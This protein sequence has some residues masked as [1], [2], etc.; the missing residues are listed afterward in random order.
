MRTIAGILIIAGL[1]MIPSSF[2]LK[3]IDYRESRNK[4][5]CKVLKGDVLLYFVFVDNKETAPWTEFDIR[6]TLDSIAT[7]VK[8]LH[9]QAAA[10]GVPLRIKTDYY[11]GKEYSTVS[12]NLTYGT[13]SKTI[14]KLGLRK[15]LEELNTWGDNVAKR[16]GSA[17]VMPEKDGIPEIKNP[18]NK[19]RLVA[20]LR[21]DH[22]V[23]SVALL[24]FLNNY[25]RVDISLQVNTFD[26]NDVEFGIVSYKYPSEIAHN[27]LHLFGAADL[28]KT[29]FRK[30]ERKIRL[31]K[32]EFPD[33]I[34]QDPYGRSI[35]SM[36]IGP[37]TRYLIGWTDSLDPAYAD[38]LTDRTY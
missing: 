31:A 24:F 29:P 38:L 32:N 1:A 28:Y 36:S 13:V 20:F 21:D 15:G 18:R 25:F 14:E 17:Y 10:A 26:T 11:I 7:A 37:L 12:R 6:T 33:D 2:S 23:E 34:M 4:N 8:W 22:A 9:N 19:E 27:F 5:V 3:R 16:V 30:S 35:E